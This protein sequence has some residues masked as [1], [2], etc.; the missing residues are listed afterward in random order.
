MQVCRTINLEKVHV[1]FLT[2]DLIHDSNTRKGLKPWHTRSTTKYPDYRYSYLW[3]SVQKFWLWKPSRKCI[4]EFFQPATRMFLSLAVRLN[5]TSWLTW[6]LYGSIRNEW[7][8]C[9]FQDTNGN[10]LK[11][12]V[13][14]P[15]TL[16]VL[17]PCKHSWLHITFFLYLR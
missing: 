9:I 8:C 4:V 3:I 7:F 17:L 10:K 2:L 14:A 5:S 16:H 15:L 13:H 12:A 1:W 11:L 6:W